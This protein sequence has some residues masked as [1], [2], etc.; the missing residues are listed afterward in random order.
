MINKRIDIAIDAGVARI[1]L[2]RPDA[3]NSIDLI[4]AEE[5]EAAAQTCAASGVRVV[6]VS[7]IGRQFCAGGDLKN[8][9]DQKN[10]GTYLEEVTSHLHAGIASLV[11]MDAPVVVAVQ[12]VAAGAGLGL[13][14]AG[15]VV[16]AGES[17]TF[18]MA[19]TRLGLTPDGSTSWYLPR[20]VG[21]LRA[22]DL[23]LTNRVLHSHEALE[24]GLIS[25]LVADDRVE[26]EAEAIVG[27]LVSGP[28]AAYGA[29]ARLLRSSWA[30]TLRIHL[31]SEAG[32]MVERANAVDG[33]E[34]IRAFIEKRAARFTGH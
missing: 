2:I 9:A 25:R 28:T 30:N 24:W 19:Y 23:T 31:L 3:A 33:P 21:L 14:C 27:Q 13:V 22:L 8:F 29:S 34:G 18:V 1:C 7:A 32:T 5:F 11:E 16:I 20:H 6:L 12:G 10:L 26:I 15:D 17:A 4:F